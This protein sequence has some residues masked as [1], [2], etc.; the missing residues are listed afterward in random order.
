M[1][2]DNS[3]RIASR[4]KAIW[5]E[6]LS[7]DNVIYQQ[8]NNLSLIAVIDATGHG[9]AAHLISQQM[10]RFIEA[11]TDWSDPAAMIVEL[12][13]ALSPCIGAAVGIAVIDCIEHVIRFS[14]VGNISGYILGVEDRSFTFS[15]G[16]VGHKMRKAKTE[17]KPIVP[18][19]VIVLHSDGIQSRFYTQYDNDCKL[20]SAPQIVDYIFNNFEKEH[21]DASCIVYRY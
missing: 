4:N 13:Q 16:C 1:V 10:G 5:N 11:C 6:E 20:Q 3:H 18:G 12:H 21:D 19:D 14:G 9:K 17:I 15:D 7:G 2:L 8:H